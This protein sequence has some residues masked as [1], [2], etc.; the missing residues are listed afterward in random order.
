MRLTVH[1]LHRIDRDALVVLISCLNLF[2]NKLEAH[3]IDGQVAVYALFIAV[4]QNVHELLRIDHV[5]T[6]R[7]RIDNVLIKSDLRC[8]QTCHLI[9]LLGNEGLGRPRIF[10]VPIRPQKIVIANH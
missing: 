3:A 9:Q 2:C 10:T 6:L 4:F 7:K 8:A 5:L 1:C